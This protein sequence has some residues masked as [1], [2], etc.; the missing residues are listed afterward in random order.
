MSRDHLFG[1]PFVNL[2]FRLIDAYKAETNP[3]PIACV[4]LRPHPLGA[5]FVLGEGRGR[6]YNNKYNSAQCSKKLVKLRFEKSIYTKFWKM[7]N[8]QNQFIIPSNAHGELSK[9]AWR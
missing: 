2:S 9:L 7:K 1:S 5:D 8:Y 4:Q 6:L 3:G